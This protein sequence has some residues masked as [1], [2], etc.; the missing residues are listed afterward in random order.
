M[1]PL[2]D[3]YLP[4][5]ANSSASTQ[6]AAQRQKDHYSHFILRLA[7]AS[8]EDLRRRF[9]RVETTL[10]R[11][12]F[13]ADDTRERVA[14]VSGLGLDWELVG[15]DERRELAGELAATAPVFGRKLGPS[16]EA[17][18]FHRGR[19]VGQ[20]HRKDQCEERSLTVTRRAR[21]HSLQGLRDICNGPRCAASGRSLRSRASRRF[22]RAQDATSWSARWTSDCQGSA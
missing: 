14:F 17:V 13:G 12:R 22:D 9:A 15:E 1:K 11:L 18:L 2:V 10:F 20:A 6:L 3:K 5:D 7:F 21:E 16:E 4:L 19:R 8:P